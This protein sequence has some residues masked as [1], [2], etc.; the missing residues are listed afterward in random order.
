MSR[1]TFGY[2]LVALSV[3][4][5]GER[6]LWFE[7][8]PP[9]AQL[10]VRD[11]VTGELICDVGATADRGPALLHKDICEYWIPLWFPDGDAGPRVTLT[12]EGYEPVEVSFPIE[13]DDCARLKRPPL[14]EISVTPESS[15]P[16]PGD[17]GVGG[18]AGD[19]ANPATEGG[20]DSATDDSNTEDSSSGVDA[21][22]MPDT[23]FAPD[24]A[25]DVMLDG[26]SDALGGD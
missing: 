15:E 13:E 22:T 3:G 10:K 11:A 19:S 16:P 1:T 12:V 7:F 2:L 26:P 20:V 17:A 4:C 14:Q 8:P 24:A 5:G 23:S 25:S 21:G 9:S 6:C 18:T